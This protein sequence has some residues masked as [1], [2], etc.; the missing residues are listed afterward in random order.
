MEVSVVS[1]RLISSGRSALRAICDICIEDALMINGLKV[2][3]GSRGY[4]VAMPSRK[5]DG[6]CPH[7]G[8][9][10]HFKARFCNYCGGQ[11]PNHQSSEENNWNN[12]RLHADIAHPINNSC[13]SQI[14]ETVLRAFHSELAES[15]TGARSYELQMS[16]QRKGEAT[17]DYQE[18]ENIVDINSE[19]QMQPV[20]VPGGGLF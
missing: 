16:V 6:K 8:K 2:I 11:L 1:V 12:R 14:Q 13:R 20:K 7:C 5:I 19:N 17:Q 4:F 10:N 3:R 15:K 18:R 9:R